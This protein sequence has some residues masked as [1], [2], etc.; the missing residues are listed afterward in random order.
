MI[1]DVSPQRKC[2][3]YWPAEVQQEYGSYL[4]TVKSSRVLAYYTQRTFTVRNIHAKKV[5]P[6]ANRIRDLTYKLRGDFVWKC[7]LFY[8]SNLAQ[9]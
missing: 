9:T 7:L 6:T 4:V 1:F 2:D 3:Q 8:F 5:W